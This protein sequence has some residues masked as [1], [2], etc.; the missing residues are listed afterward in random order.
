MYVTLTALFP[1]K[2]TKK[3]VV[4]RIK[5]Y[6]RQSET[7]QYFYEEEFEEEFRVNTFDLLNSETMLSHLQHHDSI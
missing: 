4:R 3:D 1:E 5:S 6:I 7:Y 2:K